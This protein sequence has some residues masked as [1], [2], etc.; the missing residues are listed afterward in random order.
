MTEPYDPQPDRYLDSGAYAADALSPEEVAAFEAAMA[1]DPALRDEADSLRAT[2]ARLG[3]AAAEPVP[4]GLRDR[5]M[6]EVDQT[7]QD[8][9]AGSGVVVPIGSRRW[10]GTAR[11]LGAAAAVL[12]VVT[13]GVSVWGASLSRQ[14]DALVAASAEVTRVITAPDA[15]TISGPVDGQAGRGA[16]VV[17]PTLDA[18]V[19]VAEGLGAPPTGQTY[20]LWLIGADGSASSAGTFS[21]GQDGMAAVALSGSPE[22]AAAVGMTLEPQGGSTQPTTTPVLALPLA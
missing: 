13:I 19:F 21:P 5:V 18:A 3:M 10:S 17:S 15:R 9:P 16:V 12:A 22:T 2:T 1:A 20:Q 7:R 8:A 11:L 6:A 14:N 4:A